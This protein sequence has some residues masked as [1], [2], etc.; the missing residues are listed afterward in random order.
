M[1]LICSYDTPFN[2]SPSSHRLHSRQACRLISTDSTLHRRA[3]IT[4]SRPRTL[5]SASAPE[6]HLRV[7]KLR[8][9]RAAPI[10]SALSESGVNAASNR[11]LRVV[12]VLHITEHDDEL[13]AARRAWVQ[14][15]LADDYRQWRPMVE[16]SISW[17]V[18]TRHRRLRYRGVE[19]NQ[20]QLALR[21][22]AINLRRLVNLGLDHNG[23]TWALAQ[24]RTPAA[25]RPDN[26]TVTRPSTS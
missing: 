25:P 7:A 11:A 8:R 21:V 16:R 6:W 14:G 23:T 5:R 12:R 17:L 3:P 18:G 1:D 4:R 26:V 10:T 19:A 20:A 22:A 24:H 9:D 13:V 2:L 15:E